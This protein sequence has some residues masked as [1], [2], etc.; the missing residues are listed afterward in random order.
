[1]AQMHIGGHG[2]DVA[3][4][5]LHINEITADALR[6]AIEAT[7][8]QQAEPIIKAAAADLAQRITGKVEVVRDHMAFS[9]TRVY[10]AL[11][12]VKI[13]EASV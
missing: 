13:A 10:V 7:M 1:M 12:G 2:Q 9:G 6:E 4:A 8:R 11:D 3:I 5:Q